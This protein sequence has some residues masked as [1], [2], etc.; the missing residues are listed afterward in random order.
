MIMERFLLDANSFITPYKNY[1]AF[2]IVPTYWKKIEP[3][4]VRSNV[5]ILDLAYNEVLA[6]NDQLTQWITS[7]TGIAILDHKESSI[8]S[9][10]GEV[11]NYISNSPYYSSAAVRKW[12]GPNIADPWLIA[13]ASAKDYTIITFE[14]TAGIISLNNPSGKPKI[15]DIANAFHVNCKNLFEFMRKEG[16]IL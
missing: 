4:I 11:M 12:A 1:Y 15:P 5:A 8:V 16:V 10:Y 3:V 7:V 14:Q 2:D 9:K 13:A 6:G